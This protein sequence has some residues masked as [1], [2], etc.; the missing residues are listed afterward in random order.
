MPQACRSWAGTKGA[1]RFW[2]NENVTPESIRAA[3]RDK[4]I[5]RAKEYGTILA[6]Q[7]TT[8]LNYAAHK[9]TEGLGP[10]DGRGSQGIHVHSDRKSTRL[11]SSHSGESRMPSSA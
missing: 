9:A 8:S 5:E 6:V 10:I 4:T 3:H 1:Y 2:D 11:N 7:D